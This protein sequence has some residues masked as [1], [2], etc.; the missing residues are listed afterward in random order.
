[1]LIVYLT[2]A[3][4]VVILINLYFRL[5][6]L[7]YYK[8]LV[9]NEIEFNIVDIFNKEKLNKMVTFQEPVHRNHILSFAKFLK[10]GVYL[11]SLI[12]ILITFLFLWMKY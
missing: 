4:I 5:R 2:I 12:I 6:V 10:I 11:I 7:S 1:M 3:F 8:Y 9:K